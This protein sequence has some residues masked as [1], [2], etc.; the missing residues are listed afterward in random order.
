MELTTYDPPVRGLLQ[1][2][3]LT[4]V[5][6][7]EPRGFFYFVNRELGHLSALLLGIDSS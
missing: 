3:R 5:E 7:R 6:E 1:L 4:R 2:R